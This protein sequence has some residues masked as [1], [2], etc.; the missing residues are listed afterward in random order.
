MSIYVPQTPEQF[1]EA[2]ELASASELIIGKH[3]IA[4]IQ[5]PLFN[6]LTSLYL[7]TY[8]GTMVPIEDFNDA[9]MTVE[10]TTALRT[11]FAR[12]EAAGYTAMVKIENEEGEEEFISVKDEKFEEYKNLGL[13]RYYS[14][15][16]LF[17]AVL[18]EDFYYNSGNVRV[19]RGIL[20]EGPVTSKQVGASRGS[21]VQVLV[22]DYDNDTAAMFIND[23]TNISMRFLDTVGFSVNIDDISPIDPNI[24]SLRRIKEEAR[25]L[26]IEN[27]D[28][29]SKDM[30]VKE[31]EKANVEVPEFKPLKERLKE[32]WDKAVTEFEAVGPEREDIEEEEKRVDSIN[33]IFDS[34]N[35]ATAKLADEYMVPESTLRV[36]LTSGAKGSLMNAQRFYATA[37]AQKF[38]GSLPEAN[39]N[40]GRTNIY[41]PRNSLNP[42]SLGLSQK[43]FTE[44]FDPVEYLFHAI[45]GREGLTDTATQTAEAGE[46]FKALIKSLENLKVSHFGDVRDNA[47]NIFSFAYPFSP[48]YMEFVSINNQSVVSAVDMKRMVEKL[49]AKKGFDK[50]GKKLTEIKYQTRVLQLTKPD[51]TKLIDN[52]RKTEVKVIIKDAKG[53]EL[54]EKID[55]FE[56]I[57]EIKERVAAKRGVKA[58]D[59]TF[60]YKGEILDDKKFLA[61]YVNVMSNEEILRI[62][63]NQGTVSLFESKEVIKEGGV[64]LKAGQSYVNPEG[65]VKRVFAVTAPQ[66]RLS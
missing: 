61:D 51:I 19:V 57:E 30:L 49:N 56:P 33:H 26:G 28:K 42:A 48:Q 25:K 46:A 50:E 23:A 60:V 52:S 24:L 17:S 55:Y 37:G 20:T 8:K 40:T 58:S 11:F 34:Y 59:L 62:S 35:N 15:R 41:T 36:M 27:V 45:A 31:L 2:I 29:K 53:N 22:N 18:P 14:G 6:A 63:Y 47:N 13:K 44:G 64:E 4:T 43:S 21:M 5:A 10:N 9:I 3:N 12:G 32:I 54:T 65:K 39:L 1:A 7:M 66:Q 16:L 38:R